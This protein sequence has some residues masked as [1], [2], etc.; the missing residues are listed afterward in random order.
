MRPEAIDATG[1]AQVVACVLQELYVRDGVRI[2]LS[3]RIIFLFFYFLLNIFLGA[4]FWY[5]FT[6]WRYT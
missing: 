5:T 2:A 6:C 1:E 4:V 3:V